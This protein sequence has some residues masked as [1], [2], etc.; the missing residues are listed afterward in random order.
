MGINTRYLLT[1][2]ELDML[3]SVVIKKRD[4]LVSRSC[5]YLAQPEK[6]G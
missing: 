5:G 6:T 2:R 3:F 1:L 4:T